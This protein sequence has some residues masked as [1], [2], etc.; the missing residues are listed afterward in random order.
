M[1]RI[2]SPSF[3]G[4]RRL[5]Y[6]SWS[7]SNKSND[8]KLSTLYNVDIVPVVHHFSEDLVMHVCES[9]LETL[10]HYKNKGY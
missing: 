8:C 10:K 7:T 1:I 3:M 5:P 2:N 4:D 9:A 6:S